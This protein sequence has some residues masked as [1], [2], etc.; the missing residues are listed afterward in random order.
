MRPQA[1]NINGS[2]PV[3]KLAVDVVADGKRFTHRLWHA[4]PRTSTMERMKMMTQ[5]RILLGHD[6]TESAIDSV[7]KADADTMV[8][9]FEKAPDIDN[10]VL[11][12]TP[13]Q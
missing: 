12:Q 9:W 10:V 3:V 6:G 1:N 13:P 2:H 5:W 8:A 7:C 4:R 11:V